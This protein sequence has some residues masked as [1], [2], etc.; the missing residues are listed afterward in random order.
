MSEILQQIY[1]RPV[2]RE[3]ESWIVWGIEQYLQD[4]NCEYQIHAV[5]PAAESD[6]PADQRLDFSGKLLGLQMKKAHLASGERDFDRLKWD[7]HQPNGQ[8]DLVR[9]FEEIFYCFPTFINREYRW[10]ALHHC[11]FWSPGSDEDDQ[12][13][14][15]DNNRAETPNRNLRDE[16]RWGLFIEDVLR[17]DIGREVGDFDDIDEFEEE[18]QETLIELGVRTGESEEENEQKN[19]SKGNWDGFYL[20]VIEI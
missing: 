10:E 3:Y 13:A 14:W 8:F 6:W 15:Y 12:N 16:R 7:L 20:L 11:L 2:E 19:M 9:N 5:P 1:T 18:I 17:C 4:I